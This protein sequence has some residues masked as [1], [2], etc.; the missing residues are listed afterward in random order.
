MGIS[1]TK[2][3]LPVA[4]VIKDNEN[5][6]RGSSDK[7]EINEIIKSLEVPLYPE[8]LVSTFPDPK[9]KIGTT[10]TINRAPVI[11]LHDGL[12]NIEMRSWSKTVSEFLKEK[13]IDLGPLD[14]LSSSMETKLNNKDTITI[15]RIGERDE[16]VEEVIAYQKIEKP[17]NDMYKGERKLQQKGSD[18]KRIK[19]YRL[20]YENNILVSKILISD[21]VTAPSQAEIILVGTRPKI[22][23]RC[24]F[25]DTVELA[26]AKYGIDPNALCR[27]MMCESNG[28]PRSG[29]PDGQY[30]GLF[31]YEQSFWNLIAPRA[32]F[33]SGD[34]IWDATA[35]IYTTAWGWS[36]GYRG[37]WPNC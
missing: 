29:Y 6:W 17:T 21:E 24:R 35:Q 18:G 25:N 20:R 1:D 33:A 3:T 32:G 37:R 22:T 8:D 23:V 14:M 7:T 27:T 12:N 30:R 4:I 19:T 16:A 31:Q 9:L 11:Y 10:I 5:E 26:S 13:K 34:T 36:H 15:I 28:N 2:T